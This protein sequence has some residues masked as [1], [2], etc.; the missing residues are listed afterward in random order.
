MKEDR[1]AEYDVLR[2]ILVILVL[3]GHSIYYCVNTEYGG[4]EYGLKEFN[5]FGIL[6]NI[7]YYI[8]IFHMPLFFALSGALFAN[9]NLGKSKRN[10]KELVKNKFKRLIIPFIFIILK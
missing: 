9:S 4:I 2:V 8:T 7:F 6:N 3:V 1:Y 10:F 5:I